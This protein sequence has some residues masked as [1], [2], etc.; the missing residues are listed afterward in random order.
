ILELNGC[1]SQ[2][3]QV[4]YDHLLKSPGVGRREKCENYPKNHARSMNG[5]WKHQQ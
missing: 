3:F 4:K 1:T 5:G 2:V